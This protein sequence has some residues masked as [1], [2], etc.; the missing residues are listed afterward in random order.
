MK[1][2]NDKVMT[3]TYVHEKEK[4]LEKQFQKDIIKALGID[5]IVK[6][7]EKAIFDIKG[8]NNGLA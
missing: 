6:K 2:N 5:E 8:I 4:I 7:V 1:I 3:A